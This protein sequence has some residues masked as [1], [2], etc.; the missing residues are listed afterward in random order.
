MSGMTTCWFCKHDV[1]DALTQLVDFD[2][3]LL[4]VC[5]ECYARGEEAS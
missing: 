1:E 4:V 5:D 3:E 2:G